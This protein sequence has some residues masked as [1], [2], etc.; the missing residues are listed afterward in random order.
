MSPYF[1]RLFI[2]FGQFFEGV[3]EGRFAIG[4]LLFAFILT[5][6]LVAAVRFFPDA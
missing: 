6:V 4:A 1:D 2:R 3:A 5:V